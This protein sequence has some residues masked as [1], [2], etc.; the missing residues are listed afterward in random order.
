MRIAFCLG[1]ALAFTVAELALTLFL[2]EF[3]LE[4]NILSSLELASLHPIRII[5]GMMGIE[6]CFF[7]GKVVQ[8]HSQLTILSTDLFDRVV[9]DFAFKFFVDFFAIAHFL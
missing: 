8:I 3:I 1:R 4:G 9:Q 7:V 6:Q 2:Y 5:R